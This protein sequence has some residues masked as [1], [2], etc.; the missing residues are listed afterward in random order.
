VVA[1]PDASARTV[2]SVG[3]AAF[4]RIWMDPAVQGTGTGSVVAAFEHA[5]VVVTPDVAPMLADRRLS[6]W[7]G[8][9]AGREPMA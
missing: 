6:R 5:D 9:V 2:L 8:P 3:L 1:S 4:R 7:S